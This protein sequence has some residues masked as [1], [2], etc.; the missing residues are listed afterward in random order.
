[1]SFNYLGIDPGASGAF[2]IISDI[3]DVKLVGLYPDRRILIDWLK[4]ERSVSAALEKVNAM[5]GQG[6]TSMFTFG[7]T[8]GVMQ[9]ILEFAAVPFEFI[10]PGK[11]Q[12]AVLDF[13]ITDRKKRKTAITAFVLRRY[14]DLYHL[15]K[16][17]KNQGIADAICL[18]LYARLRTISFA[19]PSPKTSSTLV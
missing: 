15:L 16:V 7:T 18:A 8:Y 12:K 11:W 17:K 14:P 5:P 4:Q 3:G 19:A 2:A 10:T 6:V 13:Q 9:G 1:M